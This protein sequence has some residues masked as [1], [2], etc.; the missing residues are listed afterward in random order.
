[1]LKS[2][3]KRGLK[4]QIEFS[5]GRK[6]NMLD[7]YI[8]EPDSDRLTLSFPESKRE[9]APY[10]REGVEIKAFIFTF[11][12]IIILESIVYDSPF[13][14]K[15]IIEYN[16]EHHVIQRRK[17]LRMPYMTDFFIQLNEKNIKTTSVDICGG[18][19]RFTTNEQLKAGNT[20]QA[21][22]RISA[23]EPLIKMTGILIKKHFYKPNEYVLEFT[24]I[25]EE[26]REKIVQKC[27]NIEKE[28]NK[29][30]L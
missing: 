26:D 10:L 17:Y 12:G 3:I 24:V 1:M 18:G 16:E 28:V 23:H 6:R 20:Y 11:S 15:F 13:D 19:V 21:Q 25:D 30:S 7:T 14:G 4:V 29:T 22:L 9:F 27:L 8:L 5:I 2:P